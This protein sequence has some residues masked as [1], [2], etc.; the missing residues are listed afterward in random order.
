MTRSLG[1]LQHKTKSPPSALR[2]LE[3]LLGSLAMLATLSCGETRSDLPRPKHVVVV[4][5]DTLHAAHLSS[6]GGP[7]GLTPQIDRLAATGMQFDRA[8][9]NG[10]WTLPSTVSLFTGLTQERHGVV[11]NHHHLTDDLGV[12]PEFFSEA[13]YQTNG[14]VQMV[15]ASNHYGLDR[16]FDEY[17][18][19]GQQR[20]GAQLVAEALGWMENHSK[21]PTL[22]YLHFRRPHSPYNPDALA[23]AHFQDFERHPDPKRHEIL[24]RA[25]S[26]IRDAKLLSESE[27]G[28]VRSLY[29]A[30]LSQVDRQLEPLIDRFF[31]S[32]DMALILTSDHGEAFGQHGTLG[33]GQGIM[34][35]QIDIP[36]IFAGPGVSPGL[37]TH[38][39]STVDILPTLLEWCDIATTPSKPFEGLSLIDRLQGN[40][41]T[42]PRPV[43]LSARYPPDGPPPT[44]GVIEGRWKLTVT[45]AGDLH[46]FDRDAD[47][48]DTTNIADQ[49]PEIVARLQPLIDQ[50]RSAAEGLSTPPVEQTELSDELNE[51]L[52]A[53]GY[54]R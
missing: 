49:H 40:G 21:D 14:Y 19:F 20:S 9:S 26:Q 22:L 10:T 37:D 51:E 8:F 12:L 15:Y 41:S 45:R 47:R 39:A 42:Q 13:G 29:R 50:R 35:E 36:L 34:A 6:Y 32:E 24:A 25:D 4:V 48:A 30:N 52:Q 54:V 44:L 31:A 33:H 43:S 38:P 11:T 5:L 16:G 27:L 46:L 1:G 18:Y 17:T 2:Q 7:P 53:L 23:L 3:I 28:Y